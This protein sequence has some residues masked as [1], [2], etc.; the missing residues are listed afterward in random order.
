MGSDNEF[1]LESFAAFDDVV[2][3]DMPKLVDFVLS[4]RRMDEC[5]LGDEY[6]GLIHRGTVVEAFRRAVAQVR[7]KWQSNL[8]CHFRSGQA[9]VADLLPRQSR[10]LRLELLATLPNDKAQRWNGMLRGRD[11]DNVLARQLDFV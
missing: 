5:D 8:I 10:I 9:E 7:H 1:I 11:G 4:V 6:A 2:Q 3:M